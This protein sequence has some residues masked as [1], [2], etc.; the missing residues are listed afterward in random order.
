MTE[1]QRSRTTILLSNM[2]LSS[3]Q[4]IVHVHLKQL[5]PLSVNISVNFYVNSN[6]SVYQFTQKCDEVS[7][8]M[9]VFV[10]FVFDPWNNCLSPTYVYKEGSLQ[11]KS[12][13][14]RP[15]SGCRNTSL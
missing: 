14:S 3:T 1:N 5:L 11:I 7:V 6:D 12:D 10:F 9:I 2:G 15:V 8:D 13:I 4:H